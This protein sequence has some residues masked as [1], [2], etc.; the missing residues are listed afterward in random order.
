MS[1][2]R[3]SRFGGVSVSLGCMLLV[4]GDLLRVATGTDP[5]NMLVASGWFVQAVGAMLVALG[6]PAIYLRQAAETGAVGLVGFIGTSLYFLIFGIFGGLL[7]ALVRP[8]LAPALAKP[9]AVDLAF[10]VAALLV[11]IGGLALGVATIRAAVLPRQAGVLIL[12]GALAL[13][14]GHPLPHIEDAGLVLL[15]VGLGWLGLSLIAVPGQPVVAERKRRP[16]RTEVG[17][18]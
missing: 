18:G 17:A 11:A 1:S 2:A 3:L 6:L 10:F 15:V 4:I 5:G 16:E 12:V 14:V 13:F 7:H 8:A 9:A